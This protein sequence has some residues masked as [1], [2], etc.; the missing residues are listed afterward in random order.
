MFIYPQRVLQRLAGNVP[1]L[2]TFPSANATAPLS[3]NILDRLTMILHFSSSS[4]VLCFLM[5]LFYDGCFIFI[6]VPNNGYGICR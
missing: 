2:R 6:V 1:P 3:F 5:L 4:P